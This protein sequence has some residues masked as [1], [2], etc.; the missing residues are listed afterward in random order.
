MTHCAVIDTNVLVSALRRSHED[1]AAVRV[2]DAVF[3]GLVVPL[4]TGNIIAEYRD[5]LH[6][7]R[8]NL[9]K[10]K[11]DF[12]IAYFLDQGRLLSPVPCDLDFP[13]E[14]DRVF[15]EVALAGEA[16]AAKLVTG[17][18][19]HYPRTPIVVSAARFCEMIGR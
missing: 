15:Y 12:A 8:L 2:L 9:D 7:P 16:Y 1:S 17:N 6:R 13:D 3:D 11:C 5:V 4:Y 10:G 14:D 19:R 18:I